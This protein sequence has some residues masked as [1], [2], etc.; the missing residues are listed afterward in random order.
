MIKAKKISKTYGLLSVLNEVDLQVKTKE[1]VTITGPSGAGKTTLLNILGTL[2]VADHLP[3]RK[4]WIGGQDVFSLQGKEL[5]RFRN[6]Q[7]G[8]V[9]QSHQ[10]LPEFS[11]I[12]NVCIPAMIGKTPLYK[13]QKYAIELLDFLGLSQRADHKPAM[14]SGGEQQRVAVARALINK[15]KLLL[16]DEPSGNLDSKNADQLHKLFLTLRD[17]FDQT[18]VLVT[19]NKELAALSDRSLQLVDG[20]WS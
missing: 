4:L 10:L 7:L 6:Q 2:D 11:A 9:F 17:N 20:Q 8:F 13:A 1:I 18:I 16:A 3:D 14:L 15:P 12:E 19:H 5:A